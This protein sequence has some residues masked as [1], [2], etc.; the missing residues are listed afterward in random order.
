[1][2]LSLGVAIVVMDSPGVL[3]LIRGRDIEHYNTHSIKCY[4]LP[5]E[6]FDWVIISGYSCDEKGR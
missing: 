2:L 6:V 4:A 1:M 3:S 5:R